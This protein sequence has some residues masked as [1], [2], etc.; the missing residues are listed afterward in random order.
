MELVTLG[1]IHDLNTAIYSAG[2]HFYLS[3][4]TAGGITT[5]K[6]SAPNFA[7]PLGFV[8]K[9]DA[10]TGIILVSSAGYLPGVIATGGVSFGGASGEFDSDSTNLY[11]DDTSKRLGIGDNTPSA[12]LTIGNGT[13]G[14]N[15]FNVQ[16]AS[17]N[18][19]TQGNITLATAGGSITATGGGLTLTGAGAST[20]STSSGALSIDSAGTLNIGT[21]NATGATIGKAGITTTNSGALV[22]GQLLTGNSGATIAGGSISLNKDS[23]SNVNINTGT[24]TGL[25]TIGNSSAGAISITS[26]DDIALTADAASTWKTTSGALTVDSAAA[27]NLGTSTATSVSLGKAGITTT[28]NGAL[29]VSQLLTGSLGA[30]ISGAAINLN[31][32]SNF[33]T[34]INTGASTGAVSIGNSTAGAISITSGAAVTIVGGAASTFSTTAGSITFQPAGSATIANVQIGAGGAGS[35]TPD[36]L[37]L[38]VKS[39]T[40]DPAGG[41]EGYMYY[42]TFD[43]KFRC[44]Q[45]TGW[46]DCISAGTNYWQKAGTNISP[47]TAGDDL[48]LNSNE[49]L[50]I[51]GGTAITKHLSATSTFNI[52][53]ITSN[54][55]TNTNVTV[56]G[57]VAG[58]SV[59]ATPTAVASGVETLV[60]SWNAY[61][62]AA[63]T[64]TIRVCN[65]TSG[66]K[67]PANQTWRV[68]VWQHQTQKEWRV[69]K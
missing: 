39:T 5:T 65:H 18:I 46:T 8:V 52:A 34:N 48:L 54:S 43:N 63:D 53:S 61:V 59:A 9:S 26:N 20:W 35:A 33:A 38:D 42:N 32:S 69:Y 16:G 10:S 17:G 15:L 29:T 12:T 55:C 56:T 44:Y 67:D 22:V 1:V 64:V 47:A 60:L 37:A 68:D 45:N 58:D 6:P 66:N 14:S 27:L 51:G 28:N 19:Y 23:N 25:V 31:N 2:D 24:S 30:T 7:V 41:A 13:P 11:W 50:T 4:S 3:E 21:T 40:G 49:T 36:Y 57:A 62:S